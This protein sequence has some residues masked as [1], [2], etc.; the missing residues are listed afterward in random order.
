MLAVLY[1][2]IGES[3]EVRTIVF[4]IIIHFFFVIV[5]PHTS[6]YLILGNPLG[7]YTWRKKRKVHEPSNMKQNLG[8]DIFSKKPAVFKLFS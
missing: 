2:N 8:R 7:A 3:F 6:N 1:R 4:F 5:P